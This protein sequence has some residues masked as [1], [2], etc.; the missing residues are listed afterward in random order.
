MNNKILIISYDYNP[1]V[2]PNSFRWSSVA[3]LL[4]R[5]NYQVFVIAAWKPNLPREE[6][7]NGVHVYRV[8]GQ[9]V[10]TVRSYLQPQKEVPSQANDNS[11]SSQQLV[12]FNLVKLLHDLT[13]KNI[14]WPDFACTWFFPA[15]HKAKSILEQESIACYVTV[16]I[17]FTSHLV[18]NALKRNYPLIRWVVDISDP[19]CFLKTMNINN[20]YLYSKLN[21]KAERNIFTK[22]D[23]VSVLTQVQK[24]KYVELFHGSAGKITVN[25]NVMSIDNISSRHE[26]SL[27]NNNNKLK[28][29]FIGTLKKQVRTPETL[30]K[31][32][33]LLLNTELSDKLEL[34]FYGGVDYCQ[35][36]FL[37]YNHLIDKCIFLHGLVSRAIAIEAML[38][39]NILVNIG[40]TNPYQEPSKVVEYASTCKPIINIMSIENDSSCL[41]LKQ[42]P[43][44]F[45]IASHS[46]DESDESIYKLTQFIL[47]PPKININ[48]VDIWLRNYKLESIVDNYENIMFNK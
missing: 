1:L 38:S 36:Y 8:G 28:L 2:T 20:S 13:W 16:S 27:F 42:Y 45:N 14:Y 37:S 46:I 39:A 15:L 29:V 26:Q 6:L 30:L 25:P 44:V 5:R 18:G 41:L 7:L 34:H 32:F 21:F 12:P 17:P 24:D 3:E 22:A 19:F 9:L 47:S 33:S 23:A 11:S 10:E 43:A 48:D 40:N 35:E 4:V 31:V